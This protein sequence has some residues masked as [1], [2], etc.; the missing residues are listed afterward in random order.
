MDSICN[1]YL[2]GLGYGIS[3]FLT[4]KRNPFRKVSVRR[5]AGPTLWVHY[6]KSAFEKNNLVFV[7]HGMVERMSVTN[8]QLEDAG[9][10]VNYLIRRIAGD[11]HKKQKNKYIF[12]LSP[13]VLRYSHAT[14]TFSLEFYVRSK[15]DAK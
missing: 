3:Q 8:Q 2:D 9:I 10:P 6:I 7:K 13:I 11:P 14:Y 15:M 12:P 1:Q 4:I 5:D